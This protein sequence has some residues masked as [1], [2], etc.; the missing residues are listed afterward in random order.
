MREEGIDLWLVICRENN[1]DPVYSSLVPFTALYASRLQ[2]L[3]FHDRGA[4]GFDR[5]S[6]NFRQMGEWYKSTWDPAKMDQWARLAEVIRERNPKVIGIN[7]SERG[8]LRRRLDRLAEGQ[9]REG[10]RPGVREAR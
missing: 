9:P 8:Q 3:V 5:F 4:A 10:H 6:V 2:I 7:E 1:E